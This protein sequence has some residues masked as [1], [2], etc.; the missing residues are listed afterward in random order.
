MDM[1]V[2]ALF[3][4]TIELPLCEIASVGELDGKRA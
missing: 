1:K 3:T 4:H 2:S